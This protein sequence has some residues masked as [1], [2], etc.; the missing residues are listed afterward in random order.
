MNELKIKM[1]TQTATIKL[2]CL[3]CVPEWTGERPCGRHGD[4]MLVELVRETRS[5]MVDGRGKWAG[6]MSGKDGQ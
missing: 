3:C 2:S 5:K 4:N 1:L 6:L